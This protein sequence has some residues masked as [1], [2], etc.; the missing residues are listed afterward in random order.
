[1]S[2]FPMRAHRTFTAS[3]QSAAQARVFTRTK[4]EEWGAEEL[5]DSASL[6]VSELVTNAVIHTGTPAR[7]ALRL[8]SQDLRVEVEDQLPGRTLAIVPERPS[9]TAEQGRGLLITTS[10][11]S[12]WGVE[13][14]AT[15]KRVWVLCERNGTSE[16]ASPP[17]GTPRS[18]HE[19]G[20]RVA[21]L[22][23]SAGGD[24][25]HWSLDATTLFGWT[26][27][28]VVGR[29]LADM[30]DPAPGE[31][32]PG[33]LTDPTHA[34]A[35]WQGTYSVLCK[36]GSTVEVFASHV[37]AA[38]G[39]GTIV[40]LVAAEQRALLEH[41]ASSPKVV[42]AAGVAPVG[43][44]DDALVRLGVDE[45]LTLAVERVR[46]PISADATYLLLL[47]DLDDEFEVVALSGLPGALRGTR[48]APGSRGA[49]NARS[50]QLP[51]MV[52]DIAEFRVPLLDGTELRSL[53]V[54]PLVVEGKVIGAL[55]AA[56]A[57]VN[58]FTDDQAVLLQRFADS[59][60]VA[61]DRARLKAS[62]VERRSWLS[63]IADAGDLL[64]G[65]LDQDMT[66]AITGQIVVPRIAR[67]CAIH[68]SDERGHPVLQQVWHEDETL[69]EALRSALGTAPPD[70]LAG[71]QGT[72]L[73]SSVTTIPLIARGRQIGFLTMGR[74]RGQMLRGE[75][76]LVAESIARRAALAID[77]ARAHG[78]LQAVG[79]ALQE[80]LLPPSVPAAPGLDV[81]V[82]YE[83]AGEGAAAGGDFYD[84]FP[85]GKGKWCFVVGD[86]CG[87]GA[88]AAAVTGLARHTIQALVRA[89]FPAAAALER[90][91]T[92]ILDEGK[93]ARFLT[94][95]CGTLHLAGG[96]VHLSLVNAGH[97]PPF[98]VE[99]GGRVREI[100]TPQPLLGVIDNV[101]YTPEDLLLERG[102]LLVAVT[103]GVL[104]RR[105]AERM[106][107]EEGLVGELADTAQL[108]AQAVAERIRRL[109][110]DYSDAPQK[111]DMAI[112]AIRV[113]MG[114][115]T[116]VG[117][118][119]DV[120]A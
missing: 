63:F 14:T 44:R 102:D 59:V 74:S 78:N 12:A 10:L 49:P 96:Q 6:I 57:R 28:E 53:A 80:S 32:M 60:A 50:P 65:S 40:L 34:P 93:R 31:R 45:Y 54:V 98:L 33:D 41:P 1:M 106:L 21:V 24:V 89:G 2:P 52:P 16:V 107:G 9:D 112:M 7:L 113:E 56:S 86:V 115:A 110:A 62:E 23:L 67:W 66:M 29:P 95:V 51:V 22:E 77:N 3:S 39:A 5:A 76:Y 36:D 91:N 82:V 92:A 8:Q 30:V 116:P 13:Y 48:L 81:G 85:V 42:H 103:D 73:G 38:H 114:A 101:T 118:A 97:P 108:P 83:P 109:V 11:S 119:A 104:E 117:G 35:Q 84:L 88:E 55:A 105:D 20:V 100:G 46:D 120:V 69:V 94:L 61:A 68:L 47:R 18:V 27:D 58:G 4:L 111:D 37:R 71:R 87:T 43:L 75:F 70:Q 26:V 99:H 72:V 90:L 79:R 17:V 25:T 64:A 15:A 19:E